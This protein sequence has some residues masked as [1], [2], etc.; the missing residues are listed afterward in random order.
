MIHTTVI[1]LV[2]PVVCLGS[3]ISNLNAR[4]GPVVI[5]RAERD[6]KDMSPIVLSLNKKPSLNNSMGTEGTKASDPPFGRREGCAVDFPFVGLFDKSRGGL[7][8]RKV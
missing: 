5:K 6:N 4:E 8:L 7:E 1:H 3:N 2:E